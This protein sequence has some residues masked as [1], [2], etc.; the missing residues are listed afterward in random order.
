M[1][2]K[3]ARNRKRDRKRDRMLGTAVMLAALVLAGC[4][5]A[6]STN[7]ENN[8]EELEEAVGV[9]L[10]DVSDMFSSR[11]MEIGYD[12]EACVKITLQGDTAQSDSA[13]VQIDGA[14]V[15]VTAEGSYLLTGELQGQ[16]VVQADKADKVQ[17]ILDGV[18]VS[19]ENS[20]AL[21]V[22]QA[23]KVF[24]TTAAGSENLLET[25]GEYVAIDDHNIDGAVYARD[26]ITFNGEGLL[27]VV[28]SVG[29]GLVCKNDL[30][31][32]SG[33]YE[34]TAG[35]HGL[36]GKDSV[37]IANGDIVIN[38]AVDGIHSGNDE[39]ETVGYTYIAGGDITL[40]VGDDGIHSDTQLVVAGGSIQVTES[41]EGLEGMC[42]EITGGEIDVKASDDGLNAAGGNDES[43]GKGGFGEDVFGGSGD[44]RILISGGKLKV[45]A[46][47]DGIDSNGDLSI[48]GGEVIVYGP[49][50]GG[51]GALDYSGSGTITGG[52]VI[53]LGA[54]QM[55]QN[56][57]DTSTQCSM[58]VNLQ[59]TVEAG[60][61][62]ELKDLTGQVLMSCVSE[63]SF[64][65]V[66]FSC[67]DIQVGEVYVV[68]AGDESCEIEMTDTIYGNGMGFGGPGGKGGPGRFDDGGHG[69]RGEMGG[70]NGFTSGEHGERNGERPELPDGEKP[71]LPGGEIPELPDGEIPELPDGENPEL[72]GGEKPEASGE[73][74]PSM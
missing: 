17:L 40:T 72:P 26:D 44:Y 66:V 30:V 25:T 74:G 69:G 73:S 18:N 2:G 48:S 68:T 24:V 57:G 1:R 7:A 59:N 38:A 21:Y 55:A 43:G 32:S 67:A 70:P 52:S 16:L 61:A 60:T 11:D 13:D 6:A 46:G 47:G 64:D 20:A 12:E 4:G 9:T 65:S 41:Y 27:R 3:M 19:C 37:R 22:S 23:D 53:A 35:K 5:N 15:T 54:S 36:E 28:S 33:S 51:N 62:V 63:K 58:L 39:D 50:D 31:I 10:L 49:V 56:F 71:E 34:I 8:A 29:N 14:V 42:I 45:D